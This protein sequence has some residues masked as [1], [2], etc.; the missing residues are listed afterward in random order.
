MRAPTTTR[1]KPE[2]FNPAAIA[3]LSSSE[4]EAGRSR[5]RLRTTASGIGGPFAA[6]R[7]EE[8]T[9]SGTGLPPG[10]GR[11]PY[12][13]LH[14]LDCGFFCREILFRFVHV[15]LNRACVLRA[16]FH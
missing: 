7:E 4:K 5:T 13:P 15:R 3:M 11:E 12:Q 16:R 14:S 6:A 9:A 8:N 1:G 2:S 10:P